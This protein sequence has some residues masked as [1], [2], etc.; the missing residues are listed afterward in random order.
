MVVVQPI[1]DEMNKF[2]FI[3]EEIFNLN[4]F[5]T[6]WLQELPVNHMMNLQIK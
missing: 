6:C 4:T 1:N 3:D 5:G 2:P